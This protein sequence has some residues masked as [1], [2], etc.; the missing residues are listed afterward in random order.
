MG[1]KQT[2][3]F[4]F[5]TLSELNKII[6]FLFHHWDW[7]LPHVY[8]RPWTG[9]LLGLK[10]KAGGSWTG[11]AHRGEIVQSF[12]LLKGV[13]IKKGM[14]PLLLCLLDGNLDLWYPHPGAHHPLIPLIYLCCFG[15]ISKPAGTVN[16]NNHIPHQ[17][18]RAQIN[19]ADKHVWKLWDKIEFSFANF[20]DSL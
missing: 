6:I 11:G 10:G 19:M 7:K 18:S 9:A 14:P 16:K 1:W 5:I 15:V 4:N 3:K 12:Q 17:P 8:S 2:T 13:S 20:W